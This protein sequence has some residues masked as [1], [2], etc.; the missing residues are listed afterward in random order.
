MAG[1]INKIISAVCRNIKEKWEGVEPKIAEA[2]WREYKEIGKLMI[3]AGLFLIE[4]SDEI[5]DRW[6]GG[7]I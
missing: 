4:K 5:Y 7:E 2:T 1:N 3:D 6:K